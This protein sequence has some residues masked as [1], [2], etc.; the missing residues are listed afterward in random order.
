MPRSGGIRRYLHEIAESPTTEKIAFI[1][2][3]VIL[4]AEAI[5]LIHAISLDESFVIS[6]TGFLLIVSIIELYLILKEFHEHRT[7]TTFER[8]LTIRL[9][10]FIIER[11][12]GNVSNIVTDFLNEFEEYRGS[13][14]TIYH[15]ACQIMETHKQ[16]LWEKTLRTRLKIH[17]KK[18]KKKS[19]RD[20]IDAFLK[21]YPEYQKDP[22]KVYQLTAMYIEKEK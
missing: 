14:T 13:R 20:I 2:P 17:L 12:M 4:I 7:Q 11:H 5:L 16:E 6:L 10:N 1:P 8:E 18:S 15:I 22:E 9:D 19:L 21:R 3:I